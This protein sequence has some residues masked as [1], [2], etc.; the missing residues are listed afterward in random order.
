MKMKIQKKKRIPSAV[1]YGMNLIILLIPWLTV[2]DRKL[3][4]F[5][6]IIK[7]MSVG[8]DGLMQE[9][10]TFYYEAAPGPPPLP[11]WRQHRWP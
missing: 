11:G 3:N 1:M 7:F 8:I 9:A 4:I 10:G 5:Q 6:F 2:G